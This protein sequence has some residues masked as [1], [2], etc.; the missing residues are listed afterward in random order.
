MRIWTMTTEGQIK[1]INQDC[2][3]G[4]KWIIHSGEIGIIAVADGMGGYA[5]GEQY[6]R[7]VI[8]NLRIILKKHVYSEKGLSDI[9]DKSFEDAD[10]AI[11]NYNSSKH[12][13]GGTT[14]TVVVCDGKRAL[15]KNIGDTRCYLVHDQKITQCSEDHA[16]FNENNE[17]T[18]VLTRCLGM[19]KF[20]KPFTKMVS[21]QK[22][23]R[24]IIC[25]DGFYNRLSSE[26]IEKYTVFNNEKIN[27][28]EK[29]LSILYKR[30][31]R[32][33]ISVAVIQI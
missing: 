31:E 30:N 16:I 4:K 5:Y 15:I 32:D 33:N 9:L 6:S 18:S 1:D 25:S 27:N 22:N 28:I 7:M 29:V 13:K 26:E 8:D 11:K 2:V 20:D 24:L 3:F 19:G 17:K 10:F 23:D 12:T 14:L 21:V